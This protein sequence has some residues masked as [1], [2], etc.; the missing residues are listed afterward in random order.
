MHKETEDDLVGDKALWRI[1]HEKKFVSLLGFE[2]CAFALV[3][4]FGI[5]PQATNVLESFYCMANN[6]SGYTSKKRSNVS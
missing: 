5:R 3:Q 6:I 2:A 4:A 1:L